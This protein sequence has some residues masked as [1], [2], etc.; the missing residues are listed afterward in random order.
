M[1]DLQPD[2]LSNIVTTI[3]STK[4]ISSSRIFDK[5]VKGESEED[6][7]PKNGGVELEGYT[8]KQ[9]FQITEERL[10]DERV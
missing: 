6:L 5:G 10:P 1:D 7:S 4:R 2:T 8:I 9:T 3:N